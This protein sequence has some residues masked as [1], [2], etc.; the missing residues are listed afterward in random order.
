MVL[1]DKSGKPIAYTDD[2]DTIYLFTGKPVAYFYE[3]KIYSFNGKHLGWF[4][5]GWIRDLLGACVFFSEHANGAGPVTPIK[6][7]SPIKTIKQIKPIPGIRH[8]PKIPAIKSFLWSPLS[9]E[10]FFSQ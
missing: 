8:I 10:K 1:Y 3:N 2:M 5:N 7:I 6:Q 9:G 4:E